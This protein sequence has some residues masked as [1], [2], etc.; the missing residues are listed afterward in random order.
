MK[1]LTTITLILA[2]AATT[3]KAN[4]KEDSASWKPK[5]EKTLFVV[6]ANKKLIGATVEI[7]EASGQRIAVQQLDKKKLIIDFANTGG[8]EY[9]I[10]VSKGDKKQEFQFVKN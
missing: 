7:F 3:A 1:A 8:G 6:K 2:L 9:L 4:T 5:K 10:R